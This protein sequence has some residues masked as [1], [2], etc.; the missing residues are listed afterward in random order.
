MEEHLSARL[1]LDQAKQVLDF[2]DQRVVPWLVGHDDRPRHEVG[3][4]ERRGAPLPV[5]VLTVR[6]GGVV[7][8][9][10]NA[11][12]VEELRFFAPA[13]WHLHV[14]E[15]LERVE[16]AGSRGVENETPGNERIEAR[17]RF[18]LPLSHDKLRYAGAPQAAVELRYADG[19]RQIAR[20]G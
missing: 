19:I 14:E 4:W 8:E 20:Q 12:Q 17:E 1:E 13:Q 10:R 16:A 6:A 9:M 15:F 5:P 11:E 2:R 7:Q 3:P 18:Q